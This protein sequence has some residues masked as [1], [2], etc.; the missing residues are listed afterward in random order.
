MLRKKNYRTLS[1]AESYSWPAVARGCNTFIISQN[2]DQPLGYLVPLLTHLLLNSVHVS[3]ASSSGVSEYCVNKAIHASF[4]SF[5]T[6]CSP[7]ADSG[8]AV[9]RLGEGAASLRPAG[10]DQRFSDPSPTYHVGGHWQRS[11]QGCKNP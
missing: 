3:H 7:A 8:A 1:P 4:V 9:S 5:L 10:G 2:A 6:M 11:S